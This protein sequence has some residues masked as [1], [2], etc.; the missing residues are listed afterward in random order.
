MSSSSA[1]NVPDKILLNLSNKGLKQLTYELLDQTLSTAY[2]GPEYQ[3]LTLE[4]ITSL[5]L[6]ANLLRSLPDDI[7]SRLSSLEWLNMNQN[8]IMD[9]K[10]D[11]LDKLAGDPSQ[12]NNVLISLHVNLTK[13][14]EV[15][16]ILKR[17][18]QLKYLNGLDVD[19]EELEL[20]EE[21]N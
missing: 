17:L 16:M 7:N 10:E 19:R 5:N 14:S 2:P 1:K 20:D 8:R 3:H 6:Q 4:H 18:P 11:I 21:T 13:E 12:I 9:I 15:E